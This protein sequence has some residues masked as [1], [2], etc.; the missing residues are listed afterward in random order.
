MVLR[1]DG[2]LLIRQQFNTNTS[3][4]MQRIIASKVEKDQ[5]TYRKLFFA[6]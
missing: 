5:L 2:K 3:L 4:S 1:P 6:V